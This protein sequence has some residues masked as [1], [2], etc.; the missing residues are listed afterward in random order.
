MFR[1]LS[2]CDP[3]RRSA[4]RL[5]PAVIPPLRHARAV[6]LITKGHHRCSVDVLRCRPS[7]VARAGGPGNDPL[8]PP[9]PP[10]DLGEILCFMGISEPVSFQAPPFC[11]LRP[12]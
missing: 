12:P 1:T 10:H 8:L 2:T 3:T 7:P 4:P 11:G 9:P 5:A 6:R